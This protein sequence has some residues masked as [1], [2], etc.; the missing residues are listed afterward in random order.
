MSGKTIDG[1]CEGQKTAFQTLV[2][3]DTAYSS[4]KNNVD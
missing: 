2:T 4:D 3:F 1:L